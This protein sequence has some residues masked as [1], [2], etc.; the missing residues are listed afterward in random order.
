[1]DFISKYN[2]RLRP[3]FPISGNDLLKLTIT[4][5]DIGKNLTL[6]K[7]IWIDSDFTLNKDQLLQM[8]YN[9]K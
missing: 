8:V 7:K 1:M 9:E 6:L 4:G 5:Q 2:K 3:K